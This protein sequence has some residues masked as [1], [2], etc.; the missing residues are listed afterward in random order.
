MFIRRQAG[1]GWLTLRYRER[2]RQWSQQLLR[3]TNKPMV[4]ML[5]DYPE[6]WDA[7]TTAS[8][9]DPARRDSL[10]QRWLHRN[11]RGGR[12]P[13]IDPTLVVRLE[14][15]LQLCRQH[16]IPLVLYEMP[17]SPALR[18][19]MPPDVY[20]EFY[21]L[22]GEL[23]G[24]YAVPFYRVADLDLSIGDEHFSDVVHMNRRGATL[25]T[26]ALTQKAILPRLA[27]Q[28]RADLST[29]NSSH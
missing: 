28:T 19:K 7:R 4:P 11:L 12:Y 1:Q 3:L 22:V 9:A 18:A 5:G 27:P 25:L 10:V 24:V 6:N 29:S 21:A 23:A 20:K 8:L 14:Q 26:H 13:K 2:L 16:Q 17:V 15:T